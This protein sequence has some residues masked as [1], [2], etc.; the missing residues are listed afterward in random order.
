[1]E[2]LNEALIK[3]INRLIHTFIIGTCILVLLS[4]ACIG[5][6]AYFLCNYKSGDFRYALAFGLLTSLFLLWEVYK[7]L[8]YPP[9]F[10]EQYTPVTA[11]QYP[12]LFSLIREVSENLRIKPLRRVYICKDTTAAVFVHPTLRNII[13]E[14]ERSLVI[15]LGYLTQMDDAELRA[16][17]Y[18][19]FGHYAQKEMK[20]VVS[21]YIIAQFSRSFI[22]SYESGSS[23]SG[24]DGF[25][26]L[27]SV[28]AALI[29]RRINSKYKQLAKEMEYAADDIAIQYINA[30][31]L[32]RALIHAACI[33]YNYGMMLWGL[34][35]LKA[36][37]IQ[38]DDKYSALRM[39]CQY[40]HPPKLL[41]SAEVLKR[42][43]RLG[44]RETHIERATAGIRNSIKSANH[45]IEPEHRLCT[46]RQF[47]EWMQEG[48]T[49]YT[50]K[51]LWEKSVRLII[52]LHVKERKW[53]K[54]DSEYPVLLDN[55]KIGLGNFIKGFSIKKR[56]SPGKHTISIAENPAFKC[57]PFEFAAEPD[58]LYRAEI[59]YSYSWKTLDF[60]FYVT[61][62]TCLK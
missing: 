56:I 48:S 15:G 16:L 52:Q 41:M 25:I 53:P 5:A 38:L 59:D 50:R 27:Y 24:L 35:R 62:F 1:M 36:E 39:I 23:P 13:T 11:Q 14:P 30:H 32:Q 20:Q 10:P 8:L 54:G 58:K 61:S 18:H 17:L 43:E 51:R 4:L 40:S 57:V 49:L 45:S 34:N 28:F 46:A 44:P 6:A 47:A 19:E 33:Q 37:H 3:S 26:K 2:H 42:V 9:P 7:N 22:N 29:F 31:V 21:T 12:A 55:K 60:Q